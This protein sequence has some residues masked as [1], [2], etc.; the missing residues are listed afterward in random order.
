MAAPTAAPVVPDRTHDARVSVVVITR[1][2]VADLL[3]ALAHLR[4][5]DERPRIL[6]VDNGSGD[7]T[8]AAVR[9]RF[10]GVEVIELGEN[11]GA[12]ARTVAVERSTTPYVAFAD[13][14]SW[15]APGDL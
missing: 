12:A 14:D 5:L 7:G 8:G 4:A 13:D 9:A 1:D 6:V 10:P 2:R 3:N 15:W 11:R